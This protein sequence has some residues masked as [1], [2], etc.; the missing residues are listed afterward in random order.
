MLAEARDLASQVIEKLKLNQRPEFDAAL[1][2]A[3]PIRG[4][5]GIL[6]IIKNPMSMTPEERVLEAYYDR[7]TV[8]PV[9]KSRVI[10]IDFLSE[11]PELAA[12][13]AN[14]IMAQPDL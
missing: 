9:E 6:G 10:V 13:I 4:L 7:L 3:S 8:Y 1:A 12:R 14:A 11:D 5:L 2:G